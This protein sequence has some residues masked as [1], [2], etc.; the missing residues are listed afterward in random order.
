M[1]LT[2]Q[3][4]SFSLFTCAE[5][6]KHGSSIM[7]LRSNVK[8]SLL[9]TKSCDHTTTPKDT[10][11]TLQASNTLRNKT[12]AR[13][14]LAIHQLNTSTSVVC[15]RY[16]NLPRHPCLL[17]P[18][19]PPLNVLRLGSLAAELSRSRVSLCAR[20]SHQLH[21]NEVWFACIARQLRRNQ[22]SQTRPLSNCTSRSTTA[23]CQCGAPDSLE[24]CLYLVP[25]TCKDRSKSR[26]RCQC[27]F[28][29]DFHLRMKGLPLAP[30][31]HNGNSHHR[32]AF[33]WHPLQRPAM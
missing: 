28:D 14:C 4:A 31:P 6:P 18:Y 19:L 17:L 29:P 3:I 32:Q 10:F 30:V 20:V 15:V 23:S 12:C 9:T 25:R 24:I 21:Q 26:V 16:H 7:F 1:T 33:I 2:N 11:T 13:I 27:T 8:A 22:L 5:A